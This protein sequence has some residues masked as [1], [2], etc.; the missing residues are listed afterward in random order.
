MLQLKLNS[1]SLSETKDNKITESEN[2][3]KKRHPRN[4]KP[5]KGTIISEGA[6]HKTFSV[7]LW[8]LLGTSVEGVG[9]LAR[10]QS[11]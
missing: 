11:N 4:N 9:E 5:W 1:L 7:K 2:D 6:V 8:P 10:L 3:C